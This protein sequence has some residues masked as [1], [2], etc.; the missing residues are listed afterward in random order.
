[1]KTIRITLLLLLTFGAMTLIGFMY[2]TGPQARELV[3]NEDAT[4]RPTVPILVDWPEEF[5]RPSYHAIL[6]WNDIMPT[7][8]GARGTDLFH[9]GALEDAQRGESVVR[10]L[11]ANG[12]PCGDPWRPEAEDGHSATAYQC[13]ARADGVALWEIHV[14]APGDIHTQL[15]IAA[16]ELGHVLGLADD[17]QGA[18]IMN[19]QHCPE[20]LRVNDKDR[21]AIVER[22]QQ[23][24]E[25][26]EF[27][28]LQNLGTE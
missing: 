26:K 21:L 17:A 27:E 23:W 15:C 13:P 22:F 12:E 4:R 28:R 20:M 11:S 6:L 3:W 16:H 5:D 7:V 9:A 8:N 18:G 10:I 25:P 2:R 19:Q 14:F 24:F 1:M